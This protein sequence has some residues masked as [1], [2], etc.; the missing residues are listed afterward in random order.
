MVA[1]HRAGLRAV[2]DP[3]VVHRLL[4]LAHPR[5]HAGAQRTHTR[6]CSQRGS[7]SQPPAAGE[8]CCAPNPPC[9]GFQQS[10]GEQLPERRHPLGRERVSP[11]ALQ[12]LQYPVLGS[13][14]RVAAFQTLSWWRVCVGMGT[15][16]RC[17]RRVKLTGFMSVLLW[18]AP[19]PCTPA[20]P[21]R[22][23]GGRRLRARAVAEGDGG[24][25]TRRA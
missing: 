23:G 19:K 21:R 24:D 1:R 5:D 4:R 18:C 10:G 12:T 16:G 17:L 8:Q 14:V 22:S 7:R 3:D 20:A 25:D 11:P 13:A 15:A 6:R 9:F 2:V